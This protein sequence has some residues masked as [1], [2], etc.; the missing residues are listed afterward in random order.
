M[1]GHVAEAPY[2]LTG[3][4]S[5]PRESD[6]ELV[7]SSGPHGGRFSNRR[8]LLAAVDGE[9]ARLAS[10]MIWVF[11]AD[12][13]YLLA[14]N[15]SNRVST[16]RTACVCLQRSDTRPFDGPSALHSTT[17]QRN[18]RKADFRCGAN[19][20]RGVSFCVCPPM[21]FNHWRVF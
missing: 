12:R 4:F 1:R 14:R 13:R 15:I 11:N 3:H 18:D 16:F 7:N 9:L 19:P 8:C 6:E 21:I 5:R 10:A 20:Q 2:S 17:R